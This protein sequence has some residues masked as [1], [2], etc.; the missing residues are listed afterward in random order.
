M[1]IH[2]INRAKAVACLWVAAWLIGPMPLEAE[3]RTWRVG[4][5]AHPWTIA[6]VSGLTTWGQGWAVEIVA[7]DDGDGHID[8]DPFERIDDDGDGL[9]DEDPPNLQID[10]DG[11]GLFSEDPINGRDDDG[12]GR[13]DEDASESIDDDNDGR[14]D[15]DGPNQQIDNDGDGALN[16]D[17]LMSMGDDDGDGLFNEDPING[18]D[19]DGDGRIDEDAA[20]PVDGPGVFSTWLRPVHLDSTRNLATLIYARYLHGDYGGMPGTNL[21]NPT[22]N[23]PSE[24]GVRREQARPIGQ[25]QVIDGDLSTASILRSLVLNLKGFY[26]IDRILFRPRPILPQ[27]TVADYLIRHGDPSSINRNVLQLR[28]NPLVPQTLGQ[29]EPVVKNLRF[30]PPV[31]MGIVGLSALTPSG[32]YSETAEFSV[33]GTGFASDGTYVSEMIDVGTPTPRV[34]RY[35]RQWD[36]FPSAQRQ[37]SLEEFPDIPGDVVNWGRVRW[38][39]QRLGEGGQVRIQFRAGNT[40]DTHVY[41]RRLAPGLVDTRDE[42]G[43]PLDAFTWAKLLD[44]RIEEESLQ[45]NILGADLGADREDGWSFWSAPLKFE[46][47]LVTDD[48]SLAQRQR[49]GVPLP[50]PSGTRY[51]QFRIAFVGAPRGG[52]ALDYIEFDYDEPLMRYGAVAEIYP[53]RVSIGEEVLF[54]YVL[55]PLF[56]GTDRGYFSHIEIDVPSA[57][58]RVE[59]FSVDGIAWSDVSDTGAN[60]P[61]GR[62]QFTQAAVVDSTTERVYLAIATAP[63][64]A[65]DFRFDETVTIRFRTRLLGASQRFTARLR[66]DSELAVAQPVTDGD[67]SADI[68]TNSAQVVATNFSDM[69]GNLRVEPAVFTPNGDGL[70]DAALVDFD[71]L[72]VTDRVNVELEIYALSGVR[73]RSLSSP[74]RRAGPVR[75]AWDGRD[76]H[77]HL[78]P[79]G[80]YVYQLRVDGDTAA[81]KR[82]GTIGLAY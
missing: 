3:V 4:D 80:L 49:T 36:L 65:A 53:E 22:L 11:D 73:I 74:V 23:V 18:R 12:D 72:L 8:E 62:G 32:G 16:E 33:F 28:S 55:K 9:I 46:D 40:L 59:E 71:L 78:Q 64:T 68:A 19:D 31:L 67:A 76:E 21:N 48:M 61:L 44:K 38:S 75:I 39:G 70:N 14:I 6:P 24:N 1:F 79:P 30:D 42:D 29:Y 2:P 51:L 45:Y 35:S 77:G 69:I 25:E 7:D 81:Q 13:I 56:A 57:Q 66:N 63:M 20:R 27:A 37:Q 34:R 15:E 52:V 54:T 82:A 10:D 43:R 60:G 58:V 41:A 26:H 47:G 5:S 17:G 50:L